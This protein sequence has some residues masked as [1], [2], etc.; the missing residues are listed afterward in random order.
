MSVIQKEKVVMLQ[1]ILNNG[2]GELLDQSEPDD[3]LHYLHGFGGMV[4]GLERV[5]E[6]CVVG[7]KV[8]VTVDPADGYGEIDKDL[9]LAIE[10]DQFPEDDEFE[11]GNKSSSNLVMGTAM[12]LQSK[13]SPMTWCV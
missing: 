13:V 6:G 12:S 9:Y 8:K 4:D 11:P 2:D 10:R 3:P 1:Y 5:L 7:D